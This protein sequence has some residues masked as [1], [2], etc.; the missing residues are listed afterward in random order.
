[1]VVQRFGGPALFGGGGGCA[2]PV[3]QVAGQGGVA[4]AFG[5]FVRGIGVL[6]RVALAGGEGGFGGLGGLGGNG[7]GRAGGGV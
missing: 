1:M 2:V 4:G 3:G 5:V 6:V 7:G